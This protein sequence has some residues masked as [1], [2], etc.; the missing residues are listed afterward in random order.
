MPVPSAIS[1]LSQT[2]GSNSPAGSESP[3]TADNYLRTYAAFIAMLRDG[4]GFTS[5]TDVASA[6]T[7]DVGAVNS[8]NVRVTGTTTITSFGTNYNGPRFILF[9]QSLTLTQ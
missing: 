1:D 5:V 7:T 8:M 3:N 4:K 2:A 6:S 9:Q